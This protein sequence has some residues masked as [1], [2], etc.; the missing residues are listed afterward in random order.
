MSSPQ[1]QP[2]QD[3]LGYVL[4]QRIGAGGFGE[5]WKAIAPGGLHKAV[6]IVFGFHDDERAQSELRALE[7]V[8]E[9][10]HPFL[11]SLERIDVYQG[12]LIVVSELADKSMKTR[13]SE[14]RKQGDA[15]IP[16]SELLGYLRDAADGLDYLCNEHLLQHLDVKPENLLIVG[17]HVKVADYGLVKDIRNHNHSILGGMTPTYAAPELFDGRP[18]QLS[19]QYSLAIVYQ[20]MLTGIRPFEGRTPAELARQHLKE[21]PN[22]DPLPRGDQSVVA[23]ALSKDPNH[24]YANCMEF[25]EELSRRRASSRLKRSQSADSDS[26]SVDATQVLSS[27]DLPRSRSIETAVRLPPIECDGTEASFHPT[28]LIG[29]GRTG[30]LAL[31]TMKERLFQRFGRSDQLAA[32]HMLC[33]DTDLKDLYSITGSDERARFRDEEVLAIGLRDSDAYR[34]SGDKYSTWLSRRWIYNIPRSFTTEGIRPLGRLAFADHVDAIVE[35]LHQSIQ[36]LGDETDLNKSAAAVDMPPDPSPRIFIVGSISGGLGSGMI[37][38]LAYAVRTVLLEHG[39]SDEYLTGVFFHSLGKTAAEGG[40][41]TSNTYS[42]LKELAHYA[43]LGY[44]GDRSI[45]LP[46]FDDEFSAAFFR[47]LSA[48]LRNR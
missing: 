39:L 19:D 1:V 31:Q 47:Y 2:N 11:L 28:L 3:I 7:T 12:Q 13:Y 21:L 26:L 33:I 48:P 35:R 23:K 27:S 10:R 5:V 43:K 44:P 40:L 36:K 32:L 30:A 38:D 18:S 4:E 37:A 25:V 24:R 6:K 34:K 8:K 22:V 9:L 46:A 17:S 20:E 41:A 29:V 15:G 14:Y 16:R 42:F 45:G